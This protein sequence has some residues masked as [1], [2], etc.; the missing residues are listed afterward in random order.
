M[1][2]EKQTYNWTDNV[3]V[4]C[5]HSYAFLFFDNSTSK[6]K[7]KT[8][9]KNCVT[10]ECVVLNRYLTINIA[11]KVWSLSVKFPAR[12]AVVACCTIGVLFRTTICEVT[13][14]STTALWMSSLGKSLFSIATIFYCFQTYCEQKCGFYRGNLFFFS[15]FTLKVGHCLFVFEILRNLRTKVQQSKHFATGELNDATSTTW[16]LTNGGK[17]VHFKT[18]NHKILVYYFLLLILLLSIAH[19][20][21]RSKVIVSDPLKWGVTKFLKW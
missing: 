2:S 1:R 20:S 7:F 10:L 4:F 21:L 16:M 19:K 6:Q 14:L 3:N 5:W 8:K 12:G 17:Y 9:I 15:K 13:G 18:S 11:S